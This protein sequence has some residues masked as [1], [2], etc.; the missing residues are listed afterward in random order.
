MSRMSREPRTP[1]HAPHL[2]ALLV[3]VLV[4]VPIGARAQPA[5][6]HAQAVVLSNDGDKHFALTDYEQAIASYRE[7]YRLEAVPLLLYNIARSYRLLGAC[8]QARTFF[9]N[10]LSTSDGEYR[11]RAEQR[12]AAID[13]GT[14]D[15]CVPDKVVDVRAPTTQPGIGTTPEP[16]TGT[17][18]TT[19][20]STGL[21]TPT[22][23]GPEPVDAPRARP[24]R[25]K[26]I[27]GLVTIGAGVV[28]AG[29]GG[30]FSSRARASARDLEDRCTPGCNADD[31]AI[32]A[33]DADGKAA[34]RNAT[35][36]YGAGGVAVA[37]GAALFTWGL[38]D[39][40][41]HARHVALV[42]TRSGALAVA[43]WSF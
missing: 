10:Y 35:L 39:G 31:A 13:A 3:A 41:A 21:D 25:G 14:D 5:S 9:K 18:T 34:Q 11:E 20:P 2:H 7:A 4:L 24:G 37:A 42:P 36:L 28:L 43:G 17:G 40:R 23:R 38:L 26:R 8:G 19:Q 1:M 6:S 16:G 33:L 22:A 27:A 32:A 15:K 30:Y 12:I 29:T